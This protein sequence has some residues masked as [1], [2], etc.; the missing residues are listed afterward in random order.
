MNFFFSAVLES[1]LC[2]A[3]VAQ[4]HSRTYTRSVVVCKC[5]FTS[6]YCSF[7]QHSREARL[8]PQ[9][10]SACISHTFQCTRV[11][12]DLEH[13]AF[14][15]CFAP[16]SF[17][18]CFC[19][20]NRCAISIHNRT[21]S[22][23]GTV[24]N[25]KDYFLETRDSSFSLVVNHYLVCHKPNNKQL[26]KFNLTSQ[27]TKE[28]TRIGPYL[29]RHYKNRHQ[30]ESSSSQSE[31]EHDLNNPPR[32][33]HPTSF[34]DL[35]NDEK[36]LVREGKLTTNIFTNQMMFGRKLGWKATTKSRPKL[37]IIK[38]SPFLL[39]RHGIE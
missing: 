3:N 12:F 6:A 33:F 9:L 4:Q 25:W 20:L 24:F 28:F 7:A 16:F 26:K 21:S 29:K 13:L 36:T 37:C 2:N 31:P 10:F 14:D 34:D 1:C 35:T 11:C 5:S 27:P 8:Q 22:V 19:H 23:D 32:K 15:Y 39:N 30:K 18:M 38:S 17:I